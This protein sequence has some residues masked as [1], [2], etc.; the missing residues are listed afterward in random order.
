MNQRSNVYQLRLMH[1]TIRNDLSKEN[2]NI[3]INPVHYFIVTSE[4]AAYVTSL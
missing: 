2:V 1:C 3:V 4:N